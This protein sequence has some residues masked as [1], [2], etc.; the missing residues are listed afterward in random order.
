MKKCSEKMSH[1]EK[2]NIVGGS[3][4]SATISGLSRIPRELQGK[5]IQIAAALCA[6]AS[7]SKIM[8]GALLSPAEG[9]SGSES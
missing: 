4:T 2:L 7:G 1:L 9:L 3:L 8:S 5:K 6:A